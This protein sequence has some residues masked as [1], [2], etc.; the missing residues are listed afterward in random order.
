MGEL[1]VRDASVHRGG[2]EILRAAT[3]RVEAGHLTAVLG[4]NGSGKSTLLRVLA[5]LWPPAAGEV[6]LDG[7]PME[8]LS[9]RA[10]ARRLSFLPQDSRCDFAFTVE[11]LVSMGR[12]PHRGRF[13][14]ARGAD[15]AAVEAALARCGV[16]SLRGRFVD[17]LSGGERQRAVMARCLATDPEVLLL[18]E[19]T[20]HLDLEHALAIFELCRSLADRGRTVAIAT[21]DLGLAARYAT[22]VVLLRGGCVVASGAPEEVITPDACRDVFGVE[23]EV[24]MTP[25]GRCALVFDS[26]RERTTGVRA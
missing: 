1:L 5:G 24:A 2:R 19:P 21:H 8:A 11:E 3:L 6:V 18:D 14:A 26:L 15:R 22:R 10:V 16:A 4:P 25:S 20:T 17:S 9:R 13:D 23:A 12:H 7:Q